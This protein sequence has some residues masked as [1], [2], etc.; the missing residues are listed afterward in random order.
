M[1]IFTKALCRMLKQDIYNS[2]LKQKRIR[3]LS[4]EEIQKI[5]WKRLI[6]L[7]ENAYQ[8]SDFYH[9]IF[10]SLKIKPQDIQTYK[11]FTKLPIVDKKILNENYNKIKTKKSSEADYTISYTSGSTG[12]P[13]SYL[14][15]NKREHP[16]TSAAFMLSKESIGI[17][18]FKKINELMIKVNPESEIKNLKEPNNKETAQKLKNSMFSQIFGIKS[19]D[20]KKENIKLIDS[21][22]KNNN[23]KLIYGY[24]SNIYYLAKLYK[25][26]NLDVNIDYVIPVAESLLPQQ[27]DLISN[28]FHAQ[29]YLDYGASECMRMGFECK[30]HKGYHMDI[31]N[32]YFEYL[33]DNNQP[34]KYDENANIIVTNL[35]NYIFPLIRYKIGDQCIPTQ[36]N[37]TC[38]INYPLVSEITGRKSDAI[39]TPKNDEISLNS[40]TAVMKYYMDYIIQ[41]QLIYY[42]NT[43]SLNIKIIP[44]KTIIPTIINEIKDKISK[45]TDFSMEIKIEL[46]EDIPFDEN[47]KT[48]LLVIKKALE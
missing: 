33:D 7:L 6:Q 45:L 1:S 38:G 24:S 15:D 37:C 11:D 3:Q 8:N 34:C 20:I 48:R 46:V 13:F 41:Y 17:N 2:Y 32:Y 47:G 42:E 22:I 9:N 16:A 4:L 23:I 31:Y 14:I 29:V 27:I 5:Q 25:M 30:Q 10:T 40:F 18:P 36:Q 19:I 44:K 12:Q 21:I 26:H 39:I 43:K 35:N 28:T